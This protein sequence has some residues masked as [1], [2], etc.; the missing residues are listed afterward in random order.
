MNLVRAVFYSPLSAVAI[1]VFL[2]ALTVGLDV[3]LIIITSLVVYLI[4]FASTILLGIPTYLILNRL[5]N[6]NG[7]VYIFIGLLAPIIVGWM[8]LFFS[9]KDYSFL[10]LISIVSGFLAAF[11]T[12]TFWLC[13]VPQEV[14]DELRTTINE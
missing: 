2:M 8:T 5:N 12:Y 13:A 4:G 14:G 11:C 3:K 6:T 7:I 10:S 9:S 1:V